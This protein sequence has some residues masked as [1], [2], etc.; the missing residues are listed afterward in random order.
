MQIKYNGPKALCQ[1]IQVIELWMFFQQIT[2]LLRF[3]SEKNVVQYE[4]ILRNI[5]RIEYFKHR[6]R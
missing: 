6:N 4:N 2:M 5:Q 1:P 3:S